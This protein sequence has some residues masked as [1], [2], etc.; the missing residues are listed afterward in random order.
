MT[1]TNRQ[2]QRL[3]DLFNRRY[4]GGRLPAY[5]VRARRLEKGTGGYC[6]KT[7]ED[8]HALALSGIR[9]SARTILIDPWQLPND[10]DLHFT[11]LHELCHIRARSGHG[12]EFYK[13]MRNHC[14]QWAVN[15]EYRKLVGMTQAAY[16][17]ENWHLF[18]RSRSKVA[19]MLLE[20]GY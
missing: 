1:K 4:F 20:C 15:Y 16:M 18:A 3:F 2:L 19:E 13:Q 10:R 9:V 5:K 6:V 11:L 7:D 12:Q 17:L 8:A 14:P